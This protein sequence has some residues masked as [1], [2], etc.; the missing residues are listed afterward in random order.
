MQSC[1]DSLWVTATT[2]NNAD[3]QQVIHRCDVSRQDDGV[4]TIEMGRGNID[5]TSEMHNIS[6]TTLSA[7]VIPQLGIELYFLLATL[8]PPIFF[9]DD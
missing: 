2:T 3:I 5:C 8:L 6:A 1:Y 9:F 7:I 4:R